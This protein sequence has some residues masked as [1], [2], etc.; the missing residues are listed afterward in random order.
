M[1]VKS[2]KPYLIDELKEDIKHDVIV[3][4]REYLRGEVAKENLQSMMIAF[5]N[6]IMKINDT[7]DYNYALKDI[8]VNNYI[9]FED[10]TRWEL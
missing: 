9:Y 4:H 2:I 7:I 1:G 6:A 10:G 5:D 8:R 3:D